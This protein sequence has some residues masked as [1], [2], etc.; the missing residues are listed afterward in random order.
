MCKSSVVWISV[1]HIILG[2]TFSFC[3]QK[4][5]SQGKPN[6]RNRT[7]VCIDQYNPSFRLSDVCVLD[8]QIPKGEREMFFLKIHIPVL[9]S[10]KIPKETAPLRDFLTFSSNWTPMVYQ[11]LRQRR[12]VFNFFF[13]QLPHL[14]SNILTPPPSYGVYILNIV[15][16][17]R[18]CN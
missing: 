1:M 6:N 4:K 14:D 9:E 5:Q 16:Y 12:D 2:K 10:I 17:T 15:C 11:T 18:V 7:Y 3:L 13:M 8:E